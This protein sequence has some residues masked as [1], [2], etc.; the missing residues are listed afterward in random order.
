MQ[1][2]HISRVVDHMLR[3]YLN[4]RLLTHLVRAVDLY[5][6]RKT[7][8]CQQLSSL[9]LYFILFLLVDG[10]FLYKY[11]N[12]YHCNSYLVKYSGIPIL[13]MY[14][15]Y[16]L[17]LGLLPLSSQPLCT[18][19]SFSA[20]S[21]VDLQDCSILDLQLME[22]FV[23]GKTQVCFQFISLHVENLQQVSWAGKLA[24]Y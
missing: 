7:Q 1:N 12:L 6:P 18:Q 9:C 20:A 24:G 17:P 14:P 16:R 19:L 4:Q 5:D 15:R 10:D 21:A 23:K 11:K 13:E 8:L 3:S 22:K 2:K